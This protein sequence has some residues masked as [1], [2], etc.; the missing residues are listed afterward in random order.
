M[1]KDSLYFIIRLVV[2]LFQV[3]RLHPAFK[4]ITQYMLIDMPC[5]KSKWLTRGQ[6]LKR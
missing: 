2:C 4:K 6:D 3:M 5:A 1:V